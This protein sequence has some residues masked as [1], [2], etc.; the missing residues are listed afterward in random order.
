MTSSP[1]G[2][3]RVWVRQGA[4]LDVADWLAPQNG[5]TSATIVSAKI[6][7]VRR[8]H[9]VAPRSRLTLEKAAAG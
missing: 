2:G 1:S 8:L 9:G 4:T 3:G 5:C 6:L 7:L